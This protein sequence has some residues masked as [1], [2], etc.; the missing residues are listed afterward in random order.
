ME[1]NG[2]LA[3]VVRLRG[4]GHF[5]TPLVLSQRHRDHASLSFAFIGIY[6]PAA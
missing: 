4:E 5:L 2:P 3:G 1:K 6:H